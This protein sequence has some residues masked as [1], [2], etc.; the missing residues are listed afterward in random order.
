MLIEQLSQDTILA[1]FVI[2]G[3]ELL[4]KFSAGKKLRKVD[5]L[6]NGRAFTVYRGRRYWA[7]ELAWAWHYGHWP[8]CEVIT[9]GSVLD[10]SADNLLPVRV[11]R[12][13]FKPRA[14]EGGF[15]HS[16]CSETFADKETCRADFTERMLNIHRDEKQI[17][18]VKESRLIEIRE[19]TRVVL[20]PV[21]VKPAVSVAVEAPYPAFFAEG[22]KP[23]AVNEDGWIRFKHSSGWLYV[24][25]A[26][27]PAD[28]IRVRAEKVLQGYSKFAYSKE[29][30]RVLPVG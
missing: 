7:S 22:V 30:Q 1:N 24:P 26:C 21:R 20:A 16:L 5:L 19:H 4:R 8:T 28:D 12:Y 11:S 23:P 14:Y 17:V 18:L 6:A 25:E 2:M 27:H 15:M 29:L 13:R 10:M 9:A 3:G